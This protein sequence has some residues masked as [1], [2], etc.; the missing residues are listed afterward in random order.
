[1][2]DIFHIQTPVHCAKSW[3]ALCALVPT[4]LFLLVDTSQLGW[5]NLRFFPHNI[6]A[7]HFFGIIY[8]QVF[9]DFAGHG[10]ELPAIIPAFPD[11]PTGTSWPGTMVAGR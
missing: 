5:F 2:Q 6:T 10:M 7:P 3:A 9:V 1:M 4:F 8:P 11:I